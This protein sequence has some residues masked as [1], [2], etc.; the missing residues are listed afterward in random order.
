MNI[1]FKK[2]V[3]QYFVHSFC[4]KFGNAHDNE[5]L[6]FVYNLVYAYANEE[7]M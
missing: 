5:K 3:L 1:E 7:K 6:E 4:T 2:Y